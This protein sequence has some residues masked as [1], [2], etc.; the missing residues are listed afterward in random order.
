MNIKKVLVTSAAALVVE[1]RQTAWTTTL[2]NTLPGTNGQPLKE[3]MS[4]MVVL[5]AK[6][7][8]SSCLKTPI[9]EPLIT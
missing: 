6:E 5:N 3:E 7:S 1:S 8:S 4:L 9:S 2:E